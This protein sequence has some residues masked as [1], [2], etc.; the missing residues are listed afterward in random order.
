M[1]ASENQILRF[2]GGPDKNFIIPVY[3]RPYSWKKENC[4]QLIKDLT[5]V[6][7]RGYESHFFGSIV[8]VSQNNGACEEYTIIDG[9]QRITTVSLLLLAIRNYLLLH[10]EITGSNIKPEKIYNSYF[11][12]YNT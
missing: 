8:F 9:Q 2:I 3:Q 1:K 11:Y 6:Y 10:P 12:Y 7:K 5:D 4:V